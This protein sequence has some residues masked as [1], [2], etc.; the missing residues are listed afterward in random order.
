MT[1]DAPYK[2]SPFTLSYLL[3]RFLLCANGTEETFSSLQPV[4]EDLLKPG[5]LPASQALY[6]ISIVLNPPPLLCHLE[7][8]TASALRAAAVINT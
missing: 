3:L 8:K 2:C 6:K 1:R 7:I 4:H 5:G